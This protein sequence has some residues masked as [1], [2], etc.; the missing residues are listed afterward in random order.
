MKYV[1][2]TGRTYRLGL[3]A[4]LLCVVF[5]VWALIFH[6]DSLPL[7]A[8]A[9]VGS[10]ASTQN[11]LMALRRARLWNGG[12]SPI[13]TPWVKHDIS[14]CTFYMYDAFDAD[15]QHYRQT[16]ISALPLH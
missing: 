11:L 13:G 8:I 9:T 15:G 16:I 14:G 6:A 7:F 4:L 1:L 5:C 2:L 12:I 3:L 10:I